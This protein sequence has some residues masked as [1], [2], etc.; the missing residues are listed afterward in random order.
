M[1]H[2][3]GNFRMFEKRLDLG[4]KSEKVFAGVVVHRFDTQPVSDEEQ[5][6]APPIPHS[7]GE[8]AA[9]ISH[10]LFTVLFVRMDDRFGIGS[11]LEPMTSRKQISCKVPVV[12]DL[13]IEY[14]DHRIIFV[15][16]RL[17]AATE[18]DDAQPAM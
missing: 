2:L 16:H 1:I 5:S 6:P 4:G 3:S 13:P 18:I 8:H 10:A 12:I 14:D 17:F 9:K 15:E 11:G 7:K